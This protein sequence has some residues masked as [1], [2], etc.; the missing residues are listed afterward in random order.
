[1]TNEQRVFEYGGYHFV[2]YRQFRRGEIN[3]H[4]KGDSRPWKMDGQYAM[5]NMWTDFDLCLFADDRPHKRRD[6]S[7]ESFYAASTDRECDIFKC[8]ENGRLYVPSA[9]ELFGYTEPKQR[10]KNRDEAR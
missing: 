4:P 10:V 7:H 3:R 2:P 5:C 8:V 6:Y 9:N 1:M